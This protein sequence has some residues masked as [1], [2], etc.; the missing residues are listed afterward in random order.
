MEN[1]A[2]EGSSGKLLT[3]EVAKKAAEDAEEDFVVETAAGSRRD[4]PQLAACLSMR[5]VLVVL[6]YY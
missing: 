5:R 1:G 2:A 4:G 6:S 3:A